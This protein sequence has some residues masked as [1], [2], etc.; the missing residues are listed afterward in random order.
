MCAAADSRFESLL[1]RLGVSCDELTRALAQQT[2]VE[3][4]GNGLSGAVRGA[5]EFSNRE[6]V[7]SP[8]EVDLDYLLLGFAL[9]GRG[10]AFATLTHLGISAGD[11]RRAMDR[12]PPPGKP[13]PRDITIGLAIEGGGARLEC[14]GARFSE[15]DWTVAW[16]LSSA[17]PS[18]QRGV[19]RALNPRVEITDDVG[20]R[21]RT[22]VEV[23][24]SAWAS[25]TGV[26]RVRPI[27]PE[28]VESVMLR[29]PGLARWSRTGTAVSVDLSL[30]LRFMQRGGFHVPL[31]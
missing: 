6:A 30:E 27:P 9:V 21:Y 14:L 1:T 7:A 26:I 12:T 19:A 24:S 15:D 20:T 25:T 23:E 5:V 8:S 17:T 4:G 28:Q 16:R 22:S 18:S 3:S 31:E 13:L 10:I 11:I 2:T 29:F